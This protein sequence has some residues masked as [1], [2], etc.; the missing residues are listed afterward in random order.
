M[1]T[2]DPRPVELTGPSHLDLPSTTEPAWEPGD[3]F[4]LVGPSHLDLPHTDD[5]PVE[6]IFQPYQ[7]ALLTGVLTPW[8]VRAFPAGDFFVGADTAIYYRQTDPPQDGCRAPDWFFVPGVPARL[9][10]E[11]RRSYVLWREGV[12]P[13]LVVEYVSGSGAEERDR[14]PSTGKFW[15]YEQAIAA[16]RY[17]IWDPI[18]NRLEVYAQNGGEYQPVSPNER[19]HFPIPQMGIELGV[20]EGAYQT[21]TDRWLRA[22]DP[23]GRLLPA[24]EEQAERLAAKLRELG[25]DPDAV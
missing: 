1:A 20:W 13:L 7:T 12:R 8:L 22:W 5:A 19:G 9:D 11:L 15:V 25:L 10:G 3:P 6:N 2:A 23:N 16:S 18:R 24:P 4:R 17:V 21:I 14:T